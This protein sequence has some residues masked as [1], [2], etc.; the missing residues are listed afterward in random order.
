MYLF[1][2][3][4]FQVQESILQWMIPQNG[5]VSNGH[6]LVQLRK[7]RAIALCMMV[8][9]PSVIIL[10]IFCYFVNSPSYAFVGLLSVPLY[11]A[12]ALI[13]RMNHPDSAIYV[14]IFGAPCYFFFILKEI[15]V[16]ER[17]YLWN[18]IYLCLLF[19]TLFYSSK[20]VI[21]YLV[22]MDA[23]FFCLFAIPGY[24]NQVYTP[25]LASWGDRLIFIMFFTILGVFESTVAQGYGIALSKT[26]QMLELKMENDQLEFQINHDPLTG[27]PNQTLLQQTMEE[28]ISA[29]IAEKTSASIVVLKLDRFKDINESIGYRGGDLALHEIATRFAGCLDSTHYLARLGGTEFAILLTGAEATQSLSL[30]HKLLETFTTPLTLDNRAFTLSANIGIAVIPEHGQ[31]ATTILRNANIAMNVAQKKHQGIVIYTHEIDRYNPHRLTLIDEL[32]KAIA[33]DTLAL[34]YQPKISLF[35]SQIIGVETLTRWIHPIHGFIPPDEF[36]ALAENTG[37]IIPLTRWVIERALRQCHAW[38]QQDLHLTMAVNLSARTLY[39]QK[40]LSMITDLLQSYAISPNQLTIEITESMVMDDPEKAVKVLKSFR[41]IGIS[42]S[43]DDFGTGYS[44]LAYLK[45]FPIDEIKIDKAFVLKLSDEGNIA[46][47]AIVRAVIGMAQPLQCKIV[48]EGVENE[49]TRK[50]L[51]DIGCH[52]GQGFYFSRPIPPQA[53]EEWIETSPWGIKKSRTLAA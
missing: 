31:D 4:W 45:R 17:I 8:T 26:E 29:S 13:N 3:K 30:A 36:I 21:I 18:T 41:D 14:Y 5:P 15:P 28:T 39:D 27:L 47:E 48:A 52:I 42:V 23:A 7:T 25:E 32:R 33:E 10:S 1:L 44:S 51:Q 53:L 11:C 50:L 38:N 22:I 37:L 16:Q 34:Y 20:N 43:I 46:D 35:A 19:A 2:S 40:T 12:G 6:E 24:F 9:I 49:G